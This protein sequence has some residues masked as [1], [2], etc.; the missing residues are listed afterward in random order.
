MTV[1]E[2]LNEPKTELEKL[3]HIQGTLMGMIIHLSKGHPMKQ[4]LEQAYTYAMQLT[5]TIIN[6]EKV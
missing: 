1:E 2:I 3:G 4:Q 5:A 6:A